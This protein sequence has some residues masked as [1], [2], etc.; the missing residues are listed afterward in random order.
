M[1]KTESFTLFERERENLI[2]HL[3]NDHQVTEV[4]EGQ[5]LTDEEMVDRHSA[6]HPAV[7]RHGYYPEDHDKMLG[8]QL[9]RLVAQREAVTE[10]VRLKAVKTALAGLD[11]YALVLEAYEAQGEVLVGTGDLSG[12]LV[13]TVKDRCPEARADDF[14]TSWIKPRLDALTE[15]GKLVRHVADRGG[16]LP[17]YVRGYRNGSYYYG[18]QARID[19]AVAAA[20]ASEEARLDRE[21][22]YA[23]LGVALAGLGI[24]EVYTPDGGYG[25]AQSYRQ[26]IL[27]LDDVERLVARTTTLP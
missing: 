7:N 5:K 11:T 8:S 17:V 18:T 12:Q 26:V 6:L 3:A 9:K 23:Q 19:G 24:T 13:I 22:R 1:S 15:Q 25:R 10:A 27:R 14:P 21:R 20:T 2:P 4:L 16:S